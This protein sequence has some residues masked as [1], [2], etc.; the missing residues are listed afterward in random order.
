MNHPY[1]RLNQILPLDLYYLC[2]NPNLDWN[3]IE[4]NLEGV[5]LQL[6]NPSVYYDCNDT[7]GGYFFAREEL[8]K[9]TI[10]GDVEYYEY[11][12]ETKL[13]VQVSKDDFYR[14]IKYTNARNKIIDERVN[15]NLNFYL[16]KLY[17]TS[18]FKE[19]RQH[20]FSLDTLDFDKFIYGLDDLVLHELGITMINETPG[21]LE[22]LILEDK[23]LCAE[24]KQMEIKFINNVF[25]MAKWLT[26]DLSLNPSLKWEFVIKYPLGF[27]TTGWNLYDICYGI[28]LDTKF[29]DY[30][31]THPEGFN[32]EKWPL[33]P[34]LMNKTLNWDF[35]DENLNIFKDCV[36]SPGCGWKD[37]VSLNSSLRWSFVCKYPD[38]INGLKW[39][40]RA[41]C[42]NSNL[43][44]DFWIYVSKNPKG[45][46]GESNVYPW[47]V[48]SLSKN[49]SL[50]WNF[51]LDNPKGL[52]GNPWNMENL[53]KNSKLGKDF[54]EYI[55]K[56]DTFFGTK[57]NYNALCENTSKH[58][59]PVFFKL[60]IGLSI[61]GI[62]SLLCNKGA[63]KYIKEILNLE[64]FKSEWMGIS[65]SGSK[66]DICS[67]KYF[68]WDDFLKIINGDIYK[69]LD[70][71]D[72][73]G[74]F[75]ND[76]VTKDSRFW[77]FVK[78]NPNGFYLFN[79]EFKCFKCDWNVHCLQLCPNL[80]WSFLDIFPNGFNGKPWDCYLLIRNPSFNIEIVKKYP[81]GLNGKKWPTVWK[82]S[83]INN[84]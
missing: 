60:D 19:Y 51:V 67:N 30:I 41:L 83:C 80:D 59:I 24:I 43:G 35:I 3:F 54:F 8:S 61:S 5:K 49:A 27:D 20:F 70:L 74:L 10:F 82:K 34:L 1:D 17:E 22:T 14:G 21:I 26:N 29:Y 31:K 25:M 72:T 32:G 66:Y 9:I 56:H 73:S 46:S 7:R 84:F 68:I 79:K 62:N 38:G 58:F 65:I 69:Y 39:D 18:E 47:D 2:R 40:M 45:L 52:N 48:D 76:S 75:N 23:I 55:A 53:C 11:D 57:W 15:N 63:K 12:I 78:E 33:L 42:Y 50:S 28:K 16:Y 37:S 44:D 13:S 81:N 6:R 36:Y 64:L 77:N 4:S 71:I